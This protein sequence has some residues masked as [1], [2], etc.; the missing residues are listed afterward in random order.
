MIVAED[1]EAVGGAVEQ[2]AD[3][4]QSTG[5]NIRNGRRPGDAPEGTVFLSRTISLHGRGMLTPSVT[6]LSLAEVLVTRPLP[7]IFDLTPWNYSVVVLR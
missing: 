3:I 7:K 5:A 2:A 6:S 1:N 4:A